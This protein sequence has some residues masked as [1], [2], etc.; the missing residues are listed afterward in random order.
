MEIKNP[1]IEIGDYT[2]REACAILRITSPTLY[3]LMDAGKLKS[4]K[5]GRARRI[6]RAS[7]NKL[8]SG[9]NK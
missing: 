5:M 2:P 8:R 7:M 1:V 6:T 4:Y 3:K 9:D